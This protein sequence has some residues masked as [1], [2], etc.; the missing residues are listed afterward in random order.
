MKSKPQKSNNVT[1]TSWT[2]ANVR[3]QIEKRAHE[4]WLAGGCRHGEELAHWLQAEREV[5]KKRNRGQEERFS[6]NT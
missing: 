2:D 5:L 1:A 6:T 3:E 4:I